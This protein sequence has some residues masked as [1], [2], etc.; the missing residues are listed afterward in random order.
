MDLLETP[1]VTALAR[2][3]RTCVGCRQKAQRR[4]L[5][6]LVWDAISHAVVVDRQKC[7]PGRGAWLHPDVDCLKKAGRSKAIGRA[8]RRPAVEAS[9][10]LAHGITMF[11][12]LSQ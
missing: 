7:L 5:I 11:D 6:R 12:G 3:I 2:P 10:E 4:D 1:V 9:A 8:L